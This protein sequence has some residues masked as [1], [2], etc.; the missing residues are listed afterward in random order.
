MKTVLLV[1]NDSCIRD[2]VVQAFTSHPDLRLVLASSFHGAL[3]AMC[4]QDVDLVISDLSMP[5]RQGLDLLAYMA[6]YRSKVP[7]LTMSPSKPSGN[8]QGRLCW[9]GHLS[10]PLQPHGVVAHVREAL[11]SV[12]RGDYR[13]VGLH[14]LLRVLSYER[15]TCTLQVKAGLK[16][17]HLQLVRGKIV[18]AVCGEREAESAAR[19]LLSWQSPWFRMEPMPTRLHESALD[20]TLSLERVA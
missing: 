19:E 6:N 1:D 11:R 5:E 10:M 20:Q 7:V 15:D 18:H 14:D 16:A 13:P 9:R 2:L 17:G 12:E 8:T 4:E 3:W